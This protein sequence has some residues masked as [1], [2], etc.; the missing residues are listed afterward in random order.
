MY[1]MRLIE[2]IKENDTVFKLLPKLELT[3]LR[4]SILNQTEQD[5]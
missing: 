4:I 1:E 5:N 2:V 3:K